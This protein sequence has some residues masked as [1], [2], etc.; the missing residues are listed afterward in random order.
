[1]AGT[2]SASSRTMARHRASG[3]TCAAAMTHPAPTSE[4]R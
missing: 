4:K 1:M 2:E 3:H